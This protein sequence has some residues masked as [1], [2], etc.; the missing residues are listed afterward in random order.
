MKFQSIKISEKIHLALRWL[1]YLAQNQKKKPLSLTD[2]AISENLSFYF[3]QKISRLLKKKGLIKAERGARGGYFLAKHPQ[4]ISLKE[5]FEAVEGKISLIDCNNYPTCP[6][7]H[8]PSRLIWQKL[9][10]QIINLFSR[11][12]LSDIL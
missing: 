3:L 10:K 1:V 7:H 6:L 9:N 11:I 4:K 2:F 8:C 12:K 5:I